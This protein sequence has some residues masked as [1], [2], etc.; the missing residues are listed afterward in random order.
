MKTIEDTMTTR[1]PIAGPT[2]TTKLGPPSLS[3]C[4]WETNPWI[5]HVFIIIMSREI[6][7]YVYNFTYLYTKSPIC[8]ILEI[9]VHNEDCTKTQ[10]KKV[11]AVQV[12]IL[13]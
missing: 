9:T 4:S 10:E 11:K 3:S 12:C 2:V 1:R 5:N 6:H 8:V 13:S 7:L